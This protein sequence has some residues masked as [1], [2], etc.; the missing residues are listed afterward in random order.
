MIWR[1]LRSGKVRDVMESDDSGYIIMIAYDGITAF[2]QALN[3]TIPEKGKILTKMSEFWFELTKD[4][5]PNAFITCN[6]DEMNP[7]FQGENFL[8]RCMLQHNLHMIPV[9]AVVRGNITGSLWKAYSEDRV[10]EFCGVKVPEG[11][12]NSETMPEPL[13]TPTTKVPS[14]QHGQNLTYEEMIQHIRKAG[15]ANADYIASQIKTYSLKLFEY[16]SRYARA[17]GIIIADTKFEF[18]LDERGILCL[19]D[20]LLTPDSS[21]FWLSKDF[22]LGQNQPSLDKQ[23]IRDYIKAHPDVEKIP[24]DVI[25][26]TKIKYLKA[27]HM[28]TG[29]AFV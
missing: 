11:L 18:G 23:L 6:N 28:L 9:R 15:F 5:C 7:C 24:E 26:Q 1:T 3:V 17:K 20:E 27:Y 25:S 8:N 10:R 29:K 19:G 16:A 22:I 12:R 21:R 4:I 14:G 13:F 2:D